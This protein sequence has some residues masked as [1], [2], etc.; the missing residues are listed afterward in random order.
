MAWTIRPYQGAGPV[1]LGVTFDD[2]C[3]IIGYGG[4]RT[5]DASS[6]RYLLDEHKTITI[7]RNGIVEE[8]N[9]SNYY[10]DDLLFQGINLFKDNDL[11]VIARMKAMSKQKIFEFYGF[12]I[13]FD[14]GIALS[15][16]HDSDEDQ[17]SVS[18]FQNG[19]WDE[20]RDEM[21]VYKFKQ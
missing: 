4:D 20:F 13:F 21:T 9:F 10:G 14:L 19:A 18:I 6:F 11:D 12:I 7:I 2:L 3:K 15:G 1:N 8:I 17:K 16:F 5:D